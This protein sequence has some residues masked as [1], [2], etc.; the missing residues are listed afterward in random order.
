MPRAGEPQ[1]F[2][3]TGGG[4]GYAT[5]AARA[6]VGWA[7]GQPDVTA[8]VA[9]CDAGNAPSIRVL[10]HVGFTRTSEHGDKLSWRLGSSRA[11]SG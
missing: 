11:H 6:L 8:V 4:R 3:L 1:A 10:E 7:L 5:E 9:A 2:R